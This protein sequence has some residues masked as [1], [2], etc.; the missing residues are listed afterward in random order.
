MG[1][2]NGNFN[3]GFNES[4]LQKFN[5][6]FDRKGGMWRREKTPGRW[7]REKGWGK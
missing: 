1:L 3:I 7:Q 4:L 2:L 6:H 5:K